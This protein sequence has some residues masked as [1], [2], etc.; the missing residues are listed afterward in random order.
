MSRFIN[1]TSTN[2]RRRSLVKI[3]VFIAIIWFVVD[4]GRRFHSSV[5]Q[6]ELSDADIENKFFAKVNQVSHEKSMFKSLAEKLIEPAKRADEKKEASYNVQNKM[7]AEMGLRPSEWEFFE[8]QN[9]TA[10][11]YADARPEKHQ[12]LAP[13]KLS[14]DIETPSTPWK[15][16]KP[17]NIFDR[18]DLGENG[19]RVIMPVI[20][21][22][23]TQKLYDEGW[24][25]HEFNRF[26]S[27]MISTKRKLPDFRADYCKAVAPSYSK[28]LPKTSVIII[29]NNEA[30]TTLLR[31][32][33]SVLDRS[34][35][36]LI[37][38]VLLVDDFSDM[39]SL[40]WSI[41]R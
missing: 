41:P 14:V 7:Y 19:E 31:S 26:L 18:E 29:F 9:N 16:V 17:Q 2:L 36:H 15:F 32:V 10:N 11:G 1:R 24:E 27:D 4:L 30:W 37:E 39:G 5:E 13:D 38:E 12:F 34:P 40:L 6:S 25:K 28:S 3:I 35:D 21:S 23:E 33:H 8:V 22:P 20:L